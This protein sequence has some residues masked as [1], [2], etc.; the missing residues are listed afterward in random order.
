[1]SNCSKDSPS[2]QRKP[3]YPTSHPWSHDPSDMLHVVP[4]AQNP[5]LYIQA[6]P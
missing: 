6:L 4:G 2:R 1:M 3:V 5:H